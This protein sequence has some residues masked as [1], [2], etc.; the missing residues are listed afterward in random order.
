MDD[1]QAKNI[2]SR[3]TADS[4]MRRHPPPGMAL[5]PVHKCPWSIRIS[6]AT[7]V[8]GQFV[9][10]AGGQEKSPLLVR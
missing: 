1:R 7:I 6:S 10:P 3:G 4:S 9:V 2:R 5:H 8:N